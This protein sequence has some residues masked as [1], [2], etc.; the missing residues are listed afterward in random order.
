VINDEK[1]SI[2]GARKCHMQILIGLTESLK[3]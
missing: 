1:R 2:V 3:K